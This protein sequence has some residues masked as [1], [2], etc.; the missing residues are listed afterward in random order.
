MI[1]RFF[2]TQVSKTL[3]N[4]L[5]VRFGWSKFTALET[6]QSW[7]HEKIRSIST[8]WSFGRWRDRV[9]TE[10]YERP[11]RK[12]PVIVYCNINL[13]QR[14]GIWFQVFWNIIVRTKF[15]F[16]FRAFFKWNSWVA[17]FAEIIHGKVMSAM[18]WKMIVGKRK[19]YGKRE[20]GRQRDGT[21]KTPERMIN[22]GSHGR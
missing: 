8:R 6:N 12:K 3:P 22:I 13:W 5:V 4:G 21:N 11:C 20:Q 17:M 14:F 19:T 15:R 2:V 1:N 16:F 9:A 18:F 7:K 10:V